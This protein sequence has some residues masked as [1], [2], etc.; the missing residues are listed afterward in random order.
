MVV[1]SCDQAAILFAKSRGKVNSKKSLTNQIVAYFFLKI[2]YDCYTVIIH[3]ENKTKHF[4][5]C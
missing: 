3:K 1:A 5:T 4:T 2:F